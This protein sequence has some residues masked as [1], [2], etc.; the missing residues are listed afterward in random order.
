MRQVVDLHINYEFPFPIEHARADKLG[1]ISTVRLAYKNQKFLAEVNIPMLSKFP[2]ESY[3]IHAVPI[4]Q[5]NIN[6]SIPAYIQAQSNYIYLDHDKRSYSFITKEDLNNCHHTG[7]FY[8]CSYSRPTYDAD[9]DAACEYLLLNQPS[10]ESLQK[11]DLKLVTT[12]KAYWRRLKISDGWLFSMNHPTPLQILCPGQQL[13][14]IIGTGILHLKPRCSARQDYI[15]L[16]GTKELGSSEE[17]LYLPQVSLD[18]TII[19]PQISK[20]LSLVTPLPS[21]TTTKNLEPGISLDTIREAYDTIL[22]EQS[23]N[24]IHTYSHYGIGTLWIIICVFLSGLCI[25]R[26][27]RRAKRTKEEAYGPE[28]STR[29]NSSEFQILQPINVMHHPTEW[30]P[31]QPEE[32]EQDPERIPQTNNQNESSA[33][34]TPVP[35]RKN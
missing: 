25:N 18:L 19:E 3:K 35:T 2:S 10:R 31:Y 7:H 28:K 23:K 34:N 26:L 29:A 20:K 11:C 9:K 4:P 32:E 24:E 1:S 27:C 16:K 30:N 21:K 12:H 5:P 17:Y 13:T 6:E 15:T 22:A 14:T 8:I 33:H